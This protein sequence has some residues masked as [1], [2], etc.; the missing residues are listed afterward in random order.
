MLYLLDTNAVSDLMRE[1][2]QVQRRLSG[3]AA[4]D[5]VTTC[6]ISEGEI[7]WGAGRPVVDAVRRNLSLK[8]ENILASLDC[9]PVPTTAA[10]HY[11]RIRLDMQ[12][13]NVRA[14][15]EGEKLRGL[16]ENDLWIA[17]TCLALDASLVTHDGGFK[18][19]H[20]LRVEDWTW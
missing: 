10:R 19:I 16:G 20:G 18:E 15:Q 8:A 12:E 7:R 11:A 13:R 4:D 9:I 17:A 3:L 2:E 1:R 6:V 5:R 14:Q